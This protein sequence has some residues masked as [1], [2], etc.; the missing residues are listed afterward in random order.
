MDGKRMM[1]W[2]FLIVLVAVMAILA[3]PDQ[4]RGRIQKTKNDV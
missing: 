1:T 4:N 3:L 2:R